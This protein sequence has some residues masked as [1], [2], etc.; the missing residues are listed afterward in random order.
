MSNS[1]F[2]RNTALLRCGLFM[3]FVIVFGCSNPVHMNKI[4]VS[5]EIV[6]A[7][8][9]NMPLVEVLASLDSALQQ[10]DS[11]YAIYVFGAN[12]WS[13]TREIIAYPFTK[14]QKM[15]TVS[16]MPLIS[17]SS[18]YCTVESFLK[19]LEKQSAWCMRLDRTND[20]FI[21]SGH[22]VDE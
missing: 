5:N 13:K 15:Y 2:C 3:L 8:I 1:D 12:S 18:N 17:F 7:N 19:E 21:I 9:T 22:L 10:A 6:R 11:R 4:T 16:N 20:F 14:D